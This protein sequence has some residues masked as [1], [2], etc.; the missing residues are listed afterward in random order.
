MDLEQTWYQASATP[1]V[2]E[3]LGGRTLD[4]DV[5]ILGGGFAGLA[6]ARALQERG[7]KNPVLLEAQQVGHG[8]SGRNGGFVFG[9]FSR[10]PAALLADLGPAR[11]RT[12]YALS[13]DAVRTIRRR[14]DELQIDCERIEGGALWVDWFRS[15]AS[16]KALRA[17]ASLL[18]DHFGVQWDEIAPEQVRQWLET[19]RYGAALLERDA[20]HFHPLKYA[21]GL[22]AAIQRE[23]GA[24]FEHSAVQ[25]VMREGSG[26]RLNVQGGGTL[27]CQRLVVAGGGYLQRGLLPALSGARLPIATYVMV[28]EPL[29]ENL[30]PVRTPAAIYDTRFA[31]DY[32]RKLQDGRLLWG[33]RISIL[34]REPQRIAE[35]LRADLLKVYP[36]LRDVRVDFAWGGLM[37]YARHQMPQLGELAPGLWYAQSFGGHGVAPTTAA[38]ELLAEALVGAQPLDALWRRYGLSPVYGPAGLLAAQTQYSWAEFRDWLRS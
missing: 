33:G 16:L 17:E 22:A 37:S 24:V 34:E 35:L 18:R 2:F 15:P 36:Q 1:Q 19:E 4:V 38:G 21:R 32:Y 8:A 7:F 31:F 29:P 28:T 20:F 10:G 12:L 25:A 13:R 3:P 27:H 30:Q 14:I 5:A 9:G 23:G 26:W 6:T 11:A